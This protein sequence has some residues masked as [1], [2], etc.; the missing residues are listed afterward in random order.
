[1]PDIMLLPKI[2]ETLDITV[3]E[4]YSEKVAQTGRQITPYAAVPGAILD[5]ML[6][7]H[8]SAFEHG[9]LKAEDVLSDM[10]KQLRRSERKVYEVFSRDGGAVRITNSVS[11]VDMT[12]R[13]P[14][15]GEVLLSD[16][17]GELLTVI[18]DEDV[19]LLLKAMYDL[20]LEKDTGDV[21]LTEEELATE[22]GLE[23]GKC[24]PQ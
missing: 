12:F 23:R 14:E 15:A 3:N 24:L 5:A 10:K 18:G 19:R 21:F 17:V 11:Y 20:V 6:G 4:L 16:R 9:G 13:K 8:M 1:M 22:S 7:I 2:A